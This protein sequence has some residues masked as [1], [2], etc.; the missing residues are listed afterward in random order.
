MALSRPSL[1]VSPD[2]PQIPLFVG[3][4]RKKMS[5]DTGRHE[6]FV[7]S[8]LFQAAMPICENPIPGMSFV[9][10]NKLHRRQGRDQLHTHPESQGQRKNSGRQHDSRIVGK[11]HPPHPLKLRAAHALCRHWAQWLIMLSPVFAV[12]PFFL[13]F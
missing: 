12:V 3:L 11:S 5:R 4:T 10:E 6:S 13:A 8:I 1:F 2:K 7:L 9:K